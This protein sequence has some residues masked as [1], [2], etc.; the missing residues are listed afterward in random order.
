M[1]RFNAKSKSSI[2]LE[3]IRGEKTSSIASTHK[4]HP[5]QITRWKNKLET[6]AETLFSDKR[7]KNN[8]DKDRIIDELLK[9]IGQREMEIS[10]L[11]KKFKIELPRQIGHD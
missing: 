8:K 6:E 4:I 2:A 10:W 9:E 11:K 3:A 7:E 1:K 5:N